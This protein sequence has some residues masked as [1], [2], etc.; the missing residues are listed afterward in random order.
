[1]ETPQKCDYVRVIAISLNHILENS[2]KYEFDLT[3]TKMGPNG[4]KN[5]IWAC[6]D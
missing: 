6:F 5:Y 3:L 2:K 4:L 1:M